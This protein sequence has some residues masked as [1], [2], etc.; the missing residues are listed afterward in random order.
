MFRKIRKVVLI[1]AL[2]VTASYIGY[3]VG[4]RRRDKSRLVPTGKNTK[5]IDLSNFWLV[6]NK[7][8]EKYLNEEKLDAETMVHGAISGLVNSLDDPYTVYMPPEDNKV[9]QENLTGSFGGVGIRLGW[10][11]NQLAVISPL[12]QTPAAEAG[13]KAGDYILKITDQDN[14]IERTTEDITLPEAVKLIRGEIG[15]AVTLTLARESKSES[16]DVE[17]VRGEITIPALE[18]SWVEKDGRQFGHVHLMQFSKI[19]YEEW[20][21]WVE[22]VNQKKNQPDFG[23]V[24][25]DLRNNPGGYL[26]GAVYIAGEFLPRGKTVVW[27]ED[28]RGTTE[29]FEVQRSGSLSDVPLVVLVN[30]G[31]ASASEILAGALRDY[32]RAPVIGQ[33]TFGK[34]SIQ[35]PVEL[36]DDAGLHVTTARWLFPDKKSVD[37]GLEPDIQVEI[38]EEGEDFEND[39]ILEEGLEELMAEG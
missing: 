7:L 11:D 10:K 12:K 8:E 15:D 30:N 19:M 32:Q 35:E 31:S 39:I 25:L 4:L 28:Y 36:P 18:T 38:P 6:W 33:K 2:V 16:F 24:V 13:V 20:D 3:G 34:G 14:G 37:E 17:I 22:E 9:S 26:Q 21:K 23:G 27:Q 5:S 1:L 29:S